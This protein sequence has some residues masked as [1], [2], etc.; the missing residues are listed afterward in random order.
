MKKILV[1]ALL[2]TFAASTAFAANFAPTLL[3]VSADPVIQYDFDGSELVIPTTVSGTTAGLVFLVYTKDKA[4]EIADTQNGFLGWHQVNKVDTCVYY[5]TLKSV[6]IGATELTWDGKDQ[7]GGVVG[8]GEY[9]YYIWAFD[10]QGAKTLVMTQWFPGS[11]TLIKEV[12]TE[13]LPIDNPIYCSYN[14]RWNIGNDPLDESLVESTT[15]TRPT[16]WN[17][18][19]VIALDT[20]DFN[21]F[22]TEVT[23]PDAGNG[24]LMK[25]KWVP[26]GDAEIQ[27]D[28]GDNGYS[29][30]VP[31][32][33]DNEPGV[34]AVDEY[35]WTADSN[36][37]SKEADAEFYI[38]DYEGTMID[39]IDLTPW[40][41]D[42]DDGAVA[43]MN[44][45]PNDIFVRNNK[46][47]LNCH[48]SCIDQMVDPMRYLDSGEAE[49]F[50]V[51]TN[52]NGDY[53]LDHNFEETAALPW[54]CNDFNVG[55]YTYTVSADDKLFAV[56]NAYDVGAVTFGLLGPDGTGIGYMA[57]SGE[58]AGWKR[59][60][61]LV[62]SETAFDGMYLDN[63]QTGG[64]HYEW[65]KD[66]ADGSTY[67][68]GHDVITGVITNAV[69][70]EDGA[71]AAFAV[72]QNSP[73]PFNPT[74]TINFSLAQSG[75]VNIDVFNVAGQKI[76]TLVDGYMN[77]GQHSVV[78][79][80]SD[81]SAGVY[82]YTVKAG[83][84]SRTM[85]MTLVK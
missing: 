84:T 17:N 53:V 37:H 45:G 20:H 67:F 18:R 52:Q 85:K 49:D 32:A 38:F 54:V 58:T 9:A 5:S 78:W 61:L 73:N 14:R 44:G 47:F 13:G 43:Q 21:Y 57:V 2:L 10:N 4:S 8:A 28:F 79:N 82:F 70:V 69:A 31:I 3:K 30:I 36:H 74:T 16:G 15:I 48:C 34:F 64:T 22:Y 50:F 24:G 55:P 63:M 81:F 33:Q 46:A 41:S 62:D 40:W 1:F 51:W 35:L 68:L 7:D 27:T 59:G 56:V 80:A 25:W 71:P 83:N 11:A 75:N 65:D 77:A 12:D 76:D 29:D 6:G 23:N 42:P 60:E 66:K 26:A 19:G 39:V 72:D